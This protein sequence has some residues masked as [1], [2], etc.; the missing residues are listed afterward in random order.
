M[1]ELIAGQ[2]GRS[3][4]G[5]KTPLSSQRPD[6]VID[7]IV[8]KSSRSDRKKRSSVERAFGGLGGTEYRLS[9]GEYV[10][11]ED[12]AAAIEKDA[13]D[14][15]SD[16]VRDYLCRFLRG[17]VKKRPGPNKPLFKK[18]IYEQL[19]EMDYRN[20]LARIR[21][22]RKARGRAAKSE[23]PPYL[24]AIEIIQKRYKYFAMMTP[25]RFANIM[26]S[27]KSR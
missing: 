7:V 10:S 25:Q 23:K 8:P 6:V 3:P 11:G 27:R 1:A 17:K 13:D 9:K 12:L 19:A 24:E 26:S 22:E 4:V 5:R 18:L 20:E 21:A 16:R 14:V 2:A 15:L